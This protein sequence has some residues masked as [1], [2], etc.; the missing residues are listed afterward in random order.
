MK[1]SSSQ[2]MVDIY[3][4]KSMGREEHVNFFCCFF[5]NYVLRTTGPKVKERCCVVNGRDFNDHSHK[6]TKLYPEDHVELENLLDS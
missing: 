2:V 1:R 4:S 6:V 5:T 3:L